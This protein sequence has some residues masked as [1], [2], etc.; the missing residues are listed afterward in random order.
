MKER[1]PFNKYYLEHLLDKGN[2]SETWLAKDLR[3]NINVALKIYA[4]ETGLDNDGCEAVKEELSVLTNKRHKNLLSPYFFDIFESRPYAVFPYCKNGDLI[5][6]IGQFT[7]EQL[8]MMIRDISD[9]LSFLH[10]LHP[11]VIYQKI[12]PGN[13]MVDD[14]GNYLLADWRSLN[15]QSHIKKS[16]K[17]K[18]WGAGNC[19][20][21]APERFSKDSEPTIGNDIYA[22]GITAYEMITGDT[23]FED[24]GGYSQLLGESIPEFEGNYSEQLKKTIRLYLEVEP[25]ERPTAQQLTFYSETALQGEKINFKKRNTHN[26]MNIKWCLSFFKR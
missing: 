16:L 26:Y 12:W 4:P 8:W 23:P 17:Y 5:K 22:L 7:E 10:S 21:L 19:A 1:T 11:P 24:Y 2:F 15:I 14:A 25:Q 9:A 18:S 20:Y 3:T 13:I 6:S